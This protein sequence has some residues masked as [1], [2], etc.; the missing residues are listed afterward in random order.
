MSRSSKMSQL[1]HFNM[2]L[3]LL[4]RPPEAPKSNYLWILR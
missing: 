1:R 3:Q 4:Q 2:M